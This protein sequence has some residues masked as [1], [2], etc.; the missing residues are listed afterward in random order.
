MDTPCIKVCVIDPV[1]GLCAGC[2][3]SRGEIAGWTAMT[4]TE[5]RRI[6]AELPARRCGIEPAARR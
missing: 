5:R 6:M 2:L 3:R 1:T 4:D